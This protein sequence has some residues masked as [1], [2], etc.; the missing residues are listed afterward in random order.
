MEYNIPHIYTLVYRVPYRISVTRSQAHDQYRKCSH[1]Y[2]ASSTKITG[3]QAKII[4]HQH[5]WQAPKAKKYLGDVSGRDDPGTLCQIPKRAASGLQQQCWDGIKLN[6][7]STSQCKDLR[8]RAGIAC[9]KTGQ[10]QHSCCS[11]G[12]K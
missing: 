8:C 12:R 7:L 3:D 4:M 6:H 5:G 9:P 10:M 2:D 1:T 11:L